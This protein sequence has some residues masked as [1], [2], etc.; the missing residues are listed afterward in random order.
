MKADIQ[1]DGVAQI[2]AGNAIKATAPDSKLD[3]Q[4]RRDP[5]RNAKHPHRR[6]LVDAPYDSLFINYGNDYAGVTV[7]GTFAVTGNGL[8]QRRGIAT[9]YNKHASN[10]RAGIVLTAIIEFWVR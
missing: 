5:T 2:L 8:K 7:V 3:A 9:R 6:A 4:G 1:L 10:Y